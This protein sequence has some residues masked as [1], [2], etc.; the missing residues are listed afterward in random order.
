MWRIKRRRTKPKTKG[1]KVIYPKLNATAKPNR[2]QSRNTYLDV[3]CNKKLGAGCTNVGCQCQDP[4]DIPPPNITSFSDITNVSGTGV[5]DYKTRV[6]TIA[7]ASFHDFTTWYGPATNLGTTYQGVYGNSAP[8]SGNANFSLPLPAVYNHISITYNNPHPGSGGGNA[9]YIFIGGVGSG[10]LP[11][12]NPLASQAVNEIKNGT[13]GASKTYSQRYQAGD[14]LKIQEKASVITT[15]LVIELTYVP[16]IYCCKTAPYRNPI[17]GYRKHLVDACQRGIGI[18]VSGSSSLF[19][20]PVIPSNNTLMYS[21]DGINWVGLGNTVFGSRVDSVKW[22]GKIW[23]AVGGHKDTNSVAYSYDGFNWVGVGDPFSL[24]TNNGF[25]IDVAS[26]GSDWIAISNNNIIA[27]TNGIDWNPTNLPASF[28]PFGIAYGQDK[29]L[30]FGEDLN[31]S[32]KKNIWYSTDNGNSWSSVSMDGLLSI[33][34]DRGFY[35]GSLWVAVGTGTN[36]IIYSADGVNWNAG[37]NVGITGVAQDVFYNGFIWIAGGEGGQPLVWSDDGINWNPANNQPLSIV[38]GV[39]WNSS[40]NLWVATNGS[41]VSQYD[42]AYSEDGKT[43]T[44][45]PKD[46]NL[47]NTGTGNYLGSGNTDLSGYTKDVSGNVYKDNYAKT[48]ATHPEACYNQVIR[49][50]QNKNGCVDESYNYSTNQYL[51]RRCLKFQQQEFNFQSQVS[52]DASGSCTKFKSCNNCQYKT[53]GDCDCSANGFCIGINKL[54]CET[55]NTKCY[56]IYKRSNPK[57]KKQGAVSGGSRIN[58]LKYQTRMKAQGRTVNGRNNVINGR[59]PATLYRT[60]KPLTL[61][62]NTCVNPPPPPSD[63][64]YETL[65]GS[66]IVTW[67]AG[68][69][70]K[71]CRIAPLTGFTIQ[72]TGSPFGHTEPVFGNT[73]TY[74]NLPIGSYDIRVRADSYYGSSDW[75]YLYNII[76][77]T[78]PSQ[79]LNLTGTAGD[80]QVSLSWTAPMYRMHQQD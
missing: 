46:T 19:G 56:A 37:N 70:S 41:S 25:G 14:Y 61:R 27:S 49:T 20:P 22:N 76:V 42:F 21:T 57:F 38:N 40:I 55:K 53:N 68:D 2:Y 24:S 54:P 36:K 18:F 4:P 80:E 77:S 65:S 72:R 3:K 33:Y 11:T 17:L 34:A 15:A 5:V 16:N 71:L 29:W 66:I 64:S 7:P 30:L 47:M 59:R 8:P 79:V 51:T 74:S 23:V 12:E 39:T 73:Y 31:P 63:L 62:D 44:G 9:V 1:N 45:V 78:I 52:V 69:I 6:N 10:A 26:N 28:S 60:S 43:W 35:N 32:P 48:C 13:T 50:K 75:A 67:R 58:R